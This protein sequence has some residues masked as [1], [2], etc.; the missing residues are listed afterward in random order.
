METQKIILIPPTFLCLT[1][2]GQWSQS[3]WILFT[4]PSRIGRFSQSYVRRRALQKP[5]GRARKKHGWMKGVVAAWWLEE[6][7]VELELCFYNP[8]VFK[9]IGMHERLLPASP[10]W[11]CS[12]CSDV[13]SHGVLGFGAK[14]IVYLLKVSASSAAVIGMK[15][16]WPPGKV[17]AWLHACSPIVTTVVISSP[18]GELRGHTERVSGFSFCRHDGQENICASSSDDKTIKIWDVEQKV[19][20]EE[21]NVHQ[22]GLLQ[23]FYFCL[24]LVSSSISF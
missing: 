3:D 6:L 18:T 16:P 4:K 1:L 19:V 9:I 24:V 2:I 5:G 17:H 20:L 7:G 11:Y 22:V 21:H 10:N 13:N 23:N 14:N 15:L 12:R 8:L